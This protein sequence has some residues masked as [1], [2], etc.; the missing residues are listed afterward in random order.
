MRV[1]RPVQPSHIRGYPKPHDIPVIDWFRRGAAQ[2]NE[3]RQKNIWPE[4]RSP[5][6]CFWSWSPGP[7]GAVC[8]MSAPAKHH[9][10]RKKPMPP[11]FR[12]GRL[13]RQPL[14]R[15]SHPSTP[16]GALTSRIHWHP[17]FP[18]P[19]VILERTIT[20]RL[21]SA[22][23]LA[24]P[25]TKEGETAFSTISHAAGLAKIADTLSQK[26]PVYRRCARC[27]ASVWILPLCMLSRSTSIARNRSG[28]PF[29]VFT[30]TPTYQIPN[31]VETLGLRGG[32][33]TL[34]PGVQALN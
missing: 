26:P 8:G 32:R 2:G 9:I 27:L 6:P 20:W 12:W 19:Q 15:L 25:S 31:T 18:L 16:T 10:E 17:P 28:F 14:I 1:G 3:P 33:E 23:G 22:Q 5:R 34:E 24:S 11:A 30:S 7:A 4:P 29:F 21:P 13:L